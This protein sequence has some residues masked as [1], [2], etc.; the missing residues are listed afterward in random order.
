MAEGFHR[1]SDEQWNLV[2]RLSGRQTVTGIVF[3]GI[4]RLPE[5]LQPS[6]AIFAQWV[7]AVDRIEGSNERMNDVLKS[8][9][10]LF[11]DN[12]LSPVLQ[13][14]QGVGALYPEPLHRE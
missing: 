10:K 1:L 14:G 3:D 4:C 13:K 5:D 2:F 7:V 6:P 11:A 9:V 8:L 12:G